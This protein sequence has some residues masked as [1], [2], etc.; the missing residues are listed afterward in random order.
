M[1]NNQ[2]VLNVTR[3]YTLKHKQALRAVENC[4]AEWVEFGVSI[5]DLTLAESISRRNEQ[6]KIREP[7]PLAEIPGVIFQP[8]IQANNS[9]RY[10][11]LQQANQFIAQA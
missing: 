1:S 11:L 4:S 10:L 7:L 9:D 2:R 3:G 6:A 5:R 8:P